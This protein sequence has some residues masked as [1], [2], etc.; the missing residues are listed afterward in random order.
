MSEPQCSIN[1]STGYD[2]EDEN[3]DDDEDDDNNNEDLEFISLDF[4][5]K[6][7]Q[8]QVRLYDSL[9]M[10]YYMDNNGELLKSTDFD[11]TYVSE[12]SGSFKKALKQIRDFDRK[13]VNT[14][15]NIHTPIDRASFGLSEVN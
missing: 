12:T 11:D 4:S 8:A 15:K 2:E 7:G 9:G 14:A 10:L 1:I 6:N 3:E 5:L 13:H